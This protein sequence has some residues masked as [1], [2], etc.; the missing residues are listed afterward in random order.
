MQILLAWGAMVG[1]VWTALELDLMTVWSSMN[2]EWKNMV[3]VDW[4]IY[5]ILS[6]LTQM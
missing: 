3:N 4:F 2:E 5:G 1:K 6:I